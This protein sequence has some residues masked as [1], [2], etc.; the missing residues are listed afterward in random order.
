MCSGFEQTPDVI[1]IRW[2]AMEVDATP[3][4]TWKAGGW[5]PNPTLDCQSERP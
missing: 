5:A 4:S 3:S 2:Q 1:R